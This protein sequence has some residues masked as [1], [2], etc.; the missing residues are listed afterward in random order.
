MDQFDQEI[1]S[2]DYCQSF[3]GSEM[4]QARDEQIKMIGYQSVKEIKSF[5]L[6]NT[7]HESDFETDY[8]GLDV[9]IIMQIDQMINYNIYIDGKNIYTREDL[10]S[11]FPFEQFRKQPEELFS[12]QEV[13]LVLC[14]RTGKSVYVTRNIDSDEEFMSVADSISFMNGSGS[15]SKVLKTALS[16]VFI[17]QANWKNFLKMVDFTK[18]FKSVI[19]PLMIGDGNH[20]QEMFGISN[21]KAISDNRIKAIENKIDNQLSKLTSKNSELEE[22]NKESSKKITELEEKLA[23]FGM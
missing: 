5:I 11:K 16:K 22:L 2:K 15:K 4:K 6:K 19:A 21:Q 8:N 18:N 10:F 17:G 23:S 3:L 12:Q 20:I 9:E 7:N 14:V 1:D 13:A